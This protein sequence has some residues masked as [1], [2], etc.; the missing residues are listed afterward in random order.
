MADEDAGRPRA[1]GR[2]GLEAAV[3]LRPLRVGGDAAVELGLD[4]ADLPAEP[5]DALLEARAG[6]FQGGGGESV[7]VHRPH[8]DE[9]RGA[10]EEVADVPQFLG[11]EGDDGERHGLRE[12]GQHAGVEG[13]RLGRPAPRRGE[14]ADPLGLDDGDLEPGLL[15]GEGGGPFEAA[16]GLDDGP[17]GGRGAGEGR[18]R[19]TRWRCPAG[20]SGE[21]R[22]R[23]AGRTQ[24][25][26]WARPTSMPTEA[27][28][29]A[30]GSWGE[31]TG[32][33]IDRHSGWRMRA[34][35]PRRPSEFGVENRDGGPTSGAA[36]GAEPG[37]GLTVAAVSPPPRCDM[38]IGW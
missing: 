22:A 38:G 20:V 21:R 6:V 34:R 4:P 23:S 14:V 2:D 19:S 10:A 15:A 37:D 24:T 29:M 16:G 9:R 36:S 3:D 25:S 28:G 11:R 33:R 7:G 1:D 13:V 27:V 5:R 26:R 31:G 18:S 32:P 8:L 17:E 35:W 12:A 30:V